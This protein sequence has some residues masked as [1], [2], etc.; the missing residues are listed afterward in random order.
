M[1]RRRDAFSPLLIVLIPVLVVAEITAVI[2]AGPGPETDRC[3]GGCLGQCQQMILCFYHVF[4]CGWIDNQCHSNM[5]VVFSEIRGI[6]CIPVGHP[7]FVLVHCL[8]AFAIGM[9]HNTKGNRQIRIGFIGSES[10]LI[11]IQILPGIQRDAAWFR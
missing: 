10:R 11:V 1:Q 7:T 2:P 5:P 6:T 4:Q 8:D 3:T 9:F